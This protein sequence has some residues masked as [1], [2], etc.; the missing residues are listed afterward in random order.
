MTVSGSIQPSV[1]WSSK[2]AAHSYVVLGVFFNYFSVK[3]LLVF[4]V[5]FLSDY[6]IKTYEMLDIILY[7]LK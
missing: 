2:Y 3:P 5:I 6:G 7:V 4:I 1:I